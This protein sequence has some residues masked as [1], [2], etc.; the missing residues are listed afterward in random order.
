MTEVGNAKSCYLTYPSANHYYDSICDYSRLLLMEPQQLID[1][2]LQDKLGTATGPQAQALAQQ[3]HQGYLQVM[4]EILLNQLSDDQVTRLSQ[5][6]D[7]PNAQPEQ[8]Q[9]FINQEVTDLPALIDEANQQFQ[10][11]HLSRKDS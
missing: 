1:L 4:V 2:I 7:D 11:L 8:I 6:V 9:T 5:L 3:L 10:L